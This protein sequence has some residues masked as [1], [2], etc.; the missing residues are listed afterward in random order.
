MKGV[1]ECRSCARRRVAG[2]KKKERKSGGRAGN[3]DGD[4]A[5]EG[6]TKYWR[7]SAR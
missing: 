5:R 7:A 4:K 2:K 3:G 1:L 6:L